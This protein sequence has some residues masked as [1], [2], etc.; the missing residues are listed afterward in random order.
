MNN[1]MVTILGK[2][3]K[4]SKKTVAITL[5]VIMVSVV[6]TLIPPLILEKIVNRLTGGE[7]VV[8]SIAFA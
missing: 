8:L 6:M 5:L 4:K 1:G 3:V 2:L 7:M